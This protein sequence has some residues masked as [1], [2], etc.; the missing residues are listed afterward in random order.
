MALAG[1]Q[2]RSHPADQ[3]PR[4]AH[5][6]ERA[7]VDEHIWRPSG[8]NHTDRAVTAV[9]GLTRDADA[10]CTPGCSTSRPAARAPPTRAGS[11]TRRTSSWPASST[12]RSTRSAGT[13][14]PSA[15]KSPDAVAVLDAFHVVRL[16]TQVVDEVRRHVQQ[17]RARAPRLEERPALQDPR[18]AANISTTLSGAYIEVGPQAGVRLLNFRSISRICARYEAGRGSGSVMPHAVARTTCLAV[19]L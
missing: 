6:C 13:P 11:N 15:T 16:G 19:A 7:R 5:R 1:D 8:G 17:E 10:G 2:D 4:S 14:T 3:S 18:P 12:P 9:V